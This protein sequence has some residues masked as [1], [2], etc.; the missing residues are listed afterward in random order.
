MYKK[1]AD[2]EIRTMIETSPST[3]VAYIRDLERKL[4]KAQK[5]A[6]AYRDLTTGN[7]T[8]TPDYCSDFTTQFGHFVT[9][10]LGPT[11]YISYPYTDELIRETLKVIGVN[12]W[13]DLP[14]KYLRIKITDGVITDIGHITKNKWFNIRKFFK[15]K[16]EV[17]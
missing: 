15:E 16:P 2:W 12:K 17:K 14:N 13:E 1:L 11:E 10:S 7:L 4:E 8:I 6:Q 5:I 3:T 9:P